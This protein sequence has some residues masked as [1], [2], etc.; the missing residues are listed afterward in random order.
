VFSASP[1]FAV[2][3]GSRPGTSSVA[4]VAPMPDIQ[5]PAAEVVQP[6]P[7]DGPLPTVRE[8]FGLLNFGTSE[9]RIRAIQAIAQAARNG[10]EVPRMRR[11]LRIAASDSDAEVAARAQEEYDRLTEH[12]DR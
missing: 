8:S 7:V 10:S 1:V 2:A 3:A 11:A 4:P 12:D 6:R 9:E 5:A